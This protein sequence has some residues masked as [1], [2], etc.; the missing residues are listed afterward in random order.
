MESGD[1][2]QKYSPKTELDIVSWKITHQFLWRIL[3][4]EKERI[5]QIRIMG[6]RLA[7]YVST[8]NDKRFFQEFFTQNRYEYFRSRLLKADLA[9]VKRGKPP[10]IEFEP[11]IQVFEE[12]AELA[13]TDWR[14]ARDLVLIRMIERLHAL[15]WFGKNPDALTDDLIQAEQPEQ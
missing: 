10:I 4:M 6:D 2:R 15:D 1:P 9:H 13:R 3:N 8:Q 11:Y 7:E 5:D 12:G 14:L